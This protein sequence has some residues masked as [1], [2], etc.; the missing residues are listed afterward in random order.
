MSGQ[1]RS[2]LST[3]LGLELQVFLPHL[4]LFQLPMP[5]IMLE[6]YYNRLRSANY[7]VV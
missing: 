5:V 4:N 6:V 2:L 1:S 7:Q 3:G